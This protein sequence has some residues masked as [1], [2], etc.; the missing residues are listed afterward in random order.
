MNDFSLT[1]LPIGAIIIALGLAPWI[2]AFWATNNK[3]NLQIML[4]GALTTL[5]VVATVFALLFILLEL[6]GFYGIY[7][8][9][10]DIIFGSWLG[11]A[12]TQNAIHNDQFAAF[13]S[14]ENKLQDD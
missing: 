2:S 11:Y 12:I 10:L 8:M 6:I 14:G 1:I 5:A 3:S 4:K 9:M 13:I 7:L